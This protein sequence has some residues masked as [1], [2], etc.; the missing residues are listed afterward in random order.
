MRRDQRGFTLIEVL[1]ALAIF[2]FVG[3]GLLSGLRSAL[4]AE[5]LNKEHIIGENLARAVLEDV[6]FQLYEDDDDYSPISV[7]VP[8]GYSF[9]LTTVRFCAPEPC[10]PD[11]NLQKNTVAVSRGTR[12]VVTVEDLKVRR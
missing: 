10:T 12:P 5:D 8:S 7:P 4:L 1:T 2:G 9:T 11:A 6:R 3:I